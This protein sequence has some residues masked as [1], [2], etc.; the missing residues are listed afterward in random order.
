MCT[1]G[2]CLLCN[3]VRITAVSSP[4]Q[5]ES[6]RHA[7]LGHEYRHTIDHEDRHVA[8]V[9]PD[10]KLDKMKQATQGSVRRLMKMDDD[11]SGAPHQHGETL[12][13]KGET[14]SLD[15]LRS[16]RD[17]HMMRTGSSR[18]SSP[19]RLPPLS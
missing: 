9:L 10:P 18:G 4:I 16:L 8:A 3:M 15:S 11:A 19:H 1:I 13:T 17:T 2:I 14:T 6:L 7:K 12:E 5:L